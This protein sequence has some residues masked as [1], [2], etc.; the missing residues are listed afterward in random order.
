MSSC[1]KKTLSTHD[2]DLLTAECSVIAILYSVLMLLPLVHNIYKYL[3]LQKRY[4]LMLTSL[5]YLITFLLAV[6]GIMNQVAF[7]TLD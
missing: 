6:S 3:L 2:K 4:V 7:A 5:F 1:D